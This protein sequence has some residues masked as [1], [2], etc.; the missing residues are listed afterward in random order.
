MDEHQ[1]ECQYSIE[2]KVFNLK[3]LYKNIYIL[4]KN[5][6]ILLSEYSHE[7]QYSDESFTRINI[8]SWM[9]IRESNDFNYKMDEHQ[10]ECQYSSESNNFNYKILY[11]N[12]YISSWMSIL[13]NQNSLII[14][15][16]SIL[17][18]PLSRIIKSFCNKI[19]SMFK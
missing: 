4:Y 8:S 6:Y 7:C 2:S 11:K 9:S 15:W 17:A 10:S 18:N 13:A 5:I 14:K 19:N 3:I 12:I 16:M 1:S